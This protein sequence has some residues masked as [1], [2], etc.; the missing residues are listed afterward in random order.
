MTKNSDVLKVLGINSKGYGNFPKLVSKDRRLTPEAKCIY[1][2]FCSYAGSGNTAFPSVSTI[3]YDLVMGENRYYTHLKLL[4]KYS[5]ISIEKLRDE[6][7]KFDHNVYVLNAEILDTN[8]G[9]EPSLQN[10]GMDENRQEE[11][12]LQNRGLDFRGLKNEGTNTNSS[13]INNLEEEEEQTEKFPKKCIEMALKVGATKLDLAAAL[14]KMDSEPDI[15][16]PIAWLQ[17]ALENEVINRD[18]ASRPKIKR[19]PKTLAK[20]HAAKQPKTDPSR[21]DNFYL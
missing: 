9:K 6:K 17:T 12:S 8:E 15:K 7:G 18:L 10:K 16:N 5:Y 19:N 1:A 4:I 20:P 3:L 2:Y 11:P 13:R 21:Y 14:N